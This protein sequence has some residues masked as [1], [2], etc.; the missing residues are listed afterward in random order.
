MVDNLEEGYYWYYDDS[1]T[2]V[3]VYVFF[4]TIYN[5]LRVE[6]SGERESIPADCLE[7][8][9]TGPLTHP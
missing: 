6:F 2:W 7:G 9:V 5:E 1:D 4:S 3:V 8:L